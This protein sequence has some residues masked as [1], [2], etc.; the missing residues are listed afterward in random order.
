MHC[1]SQRAVLQA[2]L[3]CANIAFGEVELG[4]IYLSSV[5]TAIIEA[6]FGKWRSSSIF[7]T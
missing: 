5:Y 1:N 4:E 2:I 7:N 3:I 6:T